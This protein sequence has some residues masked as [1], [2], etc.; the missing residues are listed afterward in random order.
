MARADFRCPHC[1]HVLRVLP[2][3]GTVAPLEDA[4]TYEFESTVQGRPP[5]DLASPVVAK[6]KAKGF[7]AAEGTNAAIIGLF[8]GCLV[9]LYCWWYEIDP[10]WSVLV[11]LVVGVGIMVL[12]VVL[13]APPRLKIPQPEAKTEVIKVTMETPL[14]SGNK[15]QLDETFGVKPPA[16]RHVAQRIIDD[17]VSFSRRNCVQKGVCSQT[18]F[19]KIQEVMLARHWAMSDPD[20]PQGGV[21]LNRHGLA[22]MRAILK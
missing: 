12:R 19:D 7:W 9:W 15:I 14:P 13:Y 22:V 4:Q 6:S 21:T 17:R 16:L 20:H 3:G 11:G 8:A 5:D 10:I 2:I 18:E 1:H